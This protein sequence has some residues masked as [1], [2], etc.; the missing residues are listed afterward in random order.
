MELTD[1][2]GVRY[3]G[4]EGRYYHLDQ[5]VRPDRF[6]R[7]S[8]TRLFDTSQGVSADTMFMYRAS[9]D[10]E[11]AIDEILTRRE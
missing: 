2:D 3:V 6:G 4:W 11:E 10:Q 7:I 5:P 1:L 8:L 9:K